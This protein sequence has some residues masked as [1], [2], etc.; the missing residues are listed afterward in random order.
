MGADDLCALLLLLSA[1]VDAVMA[2]LLPM[3]GRAAA[4]PAAA[5]TADR[6]ACSCCAMVPCLGG[7]LLQAGMY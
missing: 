7:Q 6:A 3:V 1:A 5:E 2:V 4:D